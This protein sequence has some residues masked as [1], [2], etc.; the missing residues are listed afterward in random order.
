MG[1][2]AVLLIGLA[3]M[4]PPA[5]VNAGPIQGRVFDLATGGPVVDETIIVRAYAG[6][7]PNAGTPAGIVLREAQTNPDNGSFSIDVPELPAGSTDT[8]GVRLFFVRTVMG[9]PTVVAT[10]DGLRRSKNS[11]R[12]QNFDVL[13]GTTLV[14]VP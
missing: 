6:N 8:S 3:G 9:T 2:W 10:I 13:V 7:D 11:K 1:P 5:R 12:T 4:L 14:V